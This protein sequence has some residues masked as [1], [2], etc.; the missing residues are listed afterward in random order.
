MELKDC[1]D[2][3]NE[4]FIVGNDVLDYMGIVNKK[5]KKAFSQPSLL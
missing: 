3:F 2:F 5:E 1:K 4:H